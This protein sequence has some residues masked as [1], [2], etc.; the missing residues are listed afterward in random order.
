[1]VL[2]W[3]LCHSRSFLPSATSWAWSKRRQ[4]SFMNRT[5]VR[6]TTGHKFVVAVHCRKH[7]WLPDRIRYD[8]WHVILIF[9]VFNV[10]RLCYLRYRLASEGIV[11]LGV[12]LSCC[13]CVRISLGGEGNALYPVLSSLSCRHGVQLNRLFSF[14]AFILLVW[15]HSV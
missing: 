13:V 2:L 12:K 6:P 15:S 10:F 4:F 14:R 3:F 9:R 8:S 11:T 7:Y 5:I 1:M